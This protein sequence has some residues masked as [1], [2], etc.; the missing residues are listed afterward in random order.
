[1]PSA[2]K[3]QS[4][5]VRLWT[6]NGFGGDVDSFAAVPGRISKSGVKGTSNRRAG[7]SNPLRSPLEPSLARRDQII[8]RRLTHHHLV[9]ISA[10]HG[11][12]EVGFLAGNPRMLVSVALLI[13]IAYCS[14]L[15]G[16][17]S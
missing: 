2:A 9:E 1:M 6:S 13:S 15:S 4:L 12:R 14:P 8:E 16:V 5:T 11:H 10:V 17:T 7:G 3:I